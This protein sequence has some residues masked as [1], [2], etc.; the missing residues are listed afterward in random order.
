MGRQQGAYTNVAASGGGDD[1]HDVVVPVATA[2]TAG[3]DIISSDSSSFVH[4]SNDLPTA[5]K[6]D[7]DGKQ[8]GNP[9]DVGGDDDNDG[10][11]ITWEKGEVQPTA[12][13][14]VWFAV[15]F[16]AHLIAVIGTAVTFGPAALNGTTTSAQDSDGDKEQQDGMDDDNSKNY[17]PT[18]AP[19]AEFWIF[20][21]LIAVV[22][23][24]ILSITA[25]GFMSRNAQALIN[26]SLWSSVVLCG[27]AA[28]AF[29]IVAPPA[30]IIYAIFAAL[31]I[32]YAR[33]VQHKIPYAAVNLKC[34]IDAVRSNL[35]VSLVALGSMVMLVV[36]S[37]VW[38]LAFAG[39]MTLDQMKG[40]AVPDDGSSYNGGSDDDQTELS[41]LGSA[42]ACF[43]LLSFYWTH[44]VLKNVV[45]SSVAGVVGTW[46]FTPL[47]ASSFCSMAV[48]DSFIRS[49]TYSLGSIC[50]GSL[51]VALLQLLRSILR[52]AAND[53]NS[54]SNG[55]LRCIAYC[56]LSYIE[57][58]V[59][60]FNKW[61]YVYVGLYGYDYLTAG[62]R[63][64]GLFKTRGWETIIADNLV[65]RLLGIISLT[66]GLLVGLCS[67]FVAF[68]VEEFES[69]GGW[70]GAGFVVGFVI[71]LI[72]SGVVMGLLSSAVDSIIVCY[73]EAPNEF[74]ESHPHHS[75]EMQS[76]WA[77]AWP[78][79]GLRGPVVIT[80][81]GGMGIV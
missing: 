50:F 24:P 45:R 53:R 70:L 46:W 52:S 19:P 38:T 18:A 81:G 17:D 40:V 37:T 67:L 8:K 69:K 43:F 29:L 42:V 58:I 36:F 78:D 21:I 73:A 55:I 80:L 5:S 22:A 77:A 31:L 66:I 35:G 7:S 32:C 54:N 9:H 44:Q 56:I 57:R 27:V 79:L 61:A 12:F 65:N 39:T 75:Q 28:L 51:I 4:P 63:V 64:M 47:E 74:S 60:Y 13:R 10:V 34:A 71:G 15:V 1:D 2:V 59:A 26:F 23:A 30:G 49:S 3:T 6:I 11:T 68:L 76:T 20:I 72:L 25:L 16:I 48:R 62:K 33:S 41:S 14:D